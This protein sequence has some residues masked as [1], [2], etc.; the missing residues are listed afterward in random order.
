MTELYEFIVNDLKEDLTEETRKKYEKELFEKKIY[1]ES[2][3][4]IFSELI[5][6]LAKNK[7]QIDSTLASLAKVEDKFVVLN[8]TFNDGVF[9]FEDK[10]LGVQETVNFIGLDRF[11]DVSEEPVYLYH[12]LGARGRDLEPDTSEPTYLTSQHVLFTWVRRINGNLEFVIKEQNILNCDSQSI[13]EYLERKRKD[14]QAKYID[15][16]KCIQLMLKI[17]NDS[18]LLLVKCLA[19]ENYNSTLFNEIISRL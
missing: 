10:Y 16:T 7:F 6:S 5:L 2:I 9:T 14:L 17:P 3:Q 1:I 13:I 8:Y 18:L 15:C 4:R 19:E 11:S 12:Y